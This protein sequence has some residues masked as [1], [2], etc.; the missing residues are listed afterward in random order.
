[1][2]SLMEWRQSAWA[3]SH[4]VHTH[5]HMA[6]HARQKYQMEISSSF[7]MKCWGCKLQ[8]KY[9]VHLKR[10][11][12]FAKYQME[13]SSSFEMKCWVCKNIKWKYQNEMLSLQKYQMDISSSFEM[14]FWGCCEISSSNAL[15]EMSICTWKNLKGLKVTITG[16][17]F[18]LNI[19]ITWLNIFTT[20]LLPTIDKMFA[21]H[22]WHPVYACADQDCMHVS[23]AGRGR[24]ELYSYS[25]PPLISEI[26]TCLT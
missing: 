6:F 21:A 14:K 17:C 8:W 22:S 15:N 2:C 23:L 16:Q 18:W 5:T 4:S 9:Q 25:I 12:E 7:E 11:A 19:L 24:L 26:A 20:L 10:N 13:I 3:H 1:M